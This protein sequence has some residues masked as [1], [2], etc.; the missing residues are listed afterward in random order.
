MNGTSLIWDNNGIFRAWES[1]I[2]TNKTFRN[3]VLAAKNHPKK[4]QELREYYMNTLPLVAPDE[5]L[6]DKNSEYIVGPEN[7]VKDIAKAIKIINP[8]I[9]IITFVCD[10]NLRAVSKLL[11]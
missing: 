3:F 4:L 10:P 1:P 6:I 7:H 9:K 2:F 5:I 11:G 8:K